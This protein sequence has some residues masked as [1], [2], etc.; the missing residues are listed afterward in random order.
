VALFAPEEACPRV[1]Q[2]CWC[3]PC[4]K[5][6]PVLQEVQRK[7]GAERALVYAVSFKVAR[8]YAVHAI[9]K[10]FII[11]RDGTILK[12]HTG[13]GPNSIAQL[14]ADINAALRGTAEAAVGAEPAVPQ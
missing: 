10:L 14:V 12:V 6:I 3:P 13:Y 11:G 2:R 5:E 7:L 8:S 4:R 1:C 9:P